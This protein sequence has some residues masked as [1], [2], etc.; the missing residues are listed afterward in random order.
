[1]DHIGTFTATC[2]G[3]PNG[4]VPQPL[5]HLGPCGASDGG[6]GAQPFACGSS[7]TCDALTQ[8][9]EVGEGGPCCNPPSYSCKPLPAACAQDRTCACMN[10]AVPGAGCTASNGAVTMTFAYP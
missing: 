2:T 5:L 1:M 6:T 4:Y 3:L 7:L 10:T 8:Y 9:C